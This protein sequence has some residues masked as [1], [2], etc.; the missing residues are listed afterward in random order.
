MLQLQT[1][2]FSETSFYCLQIWFVGQIKFVVVDKSDKQ[3]GEN[4]I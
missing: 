3:K 1:D 4:D 2:D